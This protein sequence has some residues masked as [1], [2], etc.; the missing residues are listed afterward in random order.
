MHVHDSP[1]PP[2]DQKSSDAQNGTPQASPREATQAIP[3]Q[4][5]PSN[6]NKLPSKSPRVIAQASQRTPA[7]S[8]SAPSTF[9]LESDAPNS[10]SDAQVTPVPFG[11]RITIS[12]S[13]KILRQTAER[14]QKADP[15]PYKPSA[16]RQKPEMPRHKSQSDL[17]NSDSLRHSSSSVTKLLDSG[18]TADQVE[19]LQEFALKAGLIKPRPV[20]PKVDKTVQANPSEFEAGVQIEGRV[21]IPSPNSESISQRTPIHRSRSQGAISQRNAATPLRTPQR[22]SQQTPSTARVAQQSDRRIVVRGNPYLIRLLSYPDPSMDDMEEVVKKLEL[23]LDGI[24]EKLNRPTTTISTPSQ[25]PLTP[26]QPLQT[27]SYTL[28][29]PTVPTPSKRAQ[30]PSPLI[31]NAQRSATPRARVDW[32]WLVGGAVVLVLAI[33]YALAKLQLS[34]TA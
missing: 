12:K 20:F 28:P 9:R 30:R 18:V 23:E 7:T 15:S 27:P 1:L 13:E 26:S 10:N 25:P 34:G 2:L 31:T 24:E 33:I 3:N 22:T 17:Y 5:T 16:T 11:K 8:Q 32:W 4:A 19:E 29:A 6:A 14:N 21:V